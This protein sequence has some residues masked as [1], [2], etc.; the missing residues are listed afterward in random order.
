MDHGEQR[1]KALAI[2][3]SIVNVCG[4]EIAPNWSKKQVAPF[5]EERVAKLQDTYPL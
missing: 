3:C 1:A 2:L 5:T 4:N